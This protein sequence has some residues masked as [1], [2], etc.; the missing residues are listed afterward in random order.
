VIADAH[1]DVSEEAIE[2]VLRRG[3]GSA[4]DTLSALDQVVVS[5]GIS[6]DDEPLDEII[7]AL[8]DR[9]TARALTAVALAAQA[10]RDVRT[11]SEHLVAQLRDAFLS[12]MAPNLVQLPDRAAERVADQ[13]K[14]LGAASTVRAMEVLGEML[15]ELRHAPDPRLMLDVALVRLVNADADTSPAAL[16]ARL[17]RL[18]KTA[19]GGVAAATAPPAETPAATPVT[20]PASARAALGSRARA[21]EPPPPTSTPSPP[22]PPPSAP[23]VAAGALPTRDELTVA[24][25]DAVVPK[26]KGMAKALFL[27]GRFVGEEDGRVAFAVANDPHRKRAEPFRAEV[28]AAL[29]A[30]FGRPVPL[31]LVLDEGQ[32]PGP[33]D[34]QPSPSPSE[35]DEAIDLTQLVDAGPQSSDGGIE[36]LTRAFPGAEVIE[37]DK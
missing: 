1:L 3:G 13:G 33:F 29:A 7:E 37:E 34:R 25:A 17:E 11:I 18:E 35:P 28:E 22:S 26:L 2:A 31:T 24:W 30:H 16:L 12:L 20:G 32:R 19:A 23:A 5:G 6:F 21:L 8:I 10:G 14:R 9:D 15:V 4:R 27:P 36:R